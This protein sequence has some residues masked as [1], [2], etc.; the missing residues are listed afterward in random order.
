M[1]V[2]V[3]NSKDDTF[4]WVDDKVYQ[5]TLDEFKYSKDDNK[6]GQFSDA[7]FGILQA[8][9]YDLTE[10]KDEFIETFSDGESFIDPNS[11]LYND[12]IEMYNEYISIIGNIIDNYKGELS[13]EDLRNIR[14]INSQYSKLVEEEVG[15]V[16]V[17]EMFKRVYN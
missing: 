1:T 7:Q 11:D 9:R 13:E 15:K 8:I 17:K 3:D 14:Y 10:E 4:K 16:F 5:Y 6:D 2:D 12:I